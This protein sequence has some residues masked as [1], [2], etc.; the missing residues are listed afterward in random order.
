MFNSKKFKI[1]VRILLAVAVIL[2]IVLIFTNPI[3]KKDED[4]ELAGTEQ[5]GPT[6]PTDSTENNSDEVAPPPVLSG[7]ESTESSEE[8]PSEL[9]T[10]GPTTS[11][12]SIIGLAAVV[13]LFL[14]NTRL[15]K[16]EQSNN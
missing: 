14:L 6:G 1:F 7:T 12:I 4:A 9:T 8:M 16:A 15:V 3:S 5:T 11:V 2:T 10:T 13:Y